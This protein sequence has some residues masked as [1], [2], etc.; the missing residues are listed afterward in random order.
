MSAEQPAKLSTSSTST[1]A[2]DQTENR[3]SSEVVRRSSRKSNRLPVLVILDG[4]NKGLRFLIENVST[5]IG[6]NS[7]AD[8]CLDDA[9]ASRHHTTLYYEKGDENHPLSCTMV[10]IG[11]RNGTF[12]NGER[13]EGE[14]E[15]NDGD[16]ILIGETVL[17]FF[18][19]DAHELQ[20][21]DYVRR[22]A[23]EDMLTGLPN[24]RALETRLILECHRSEIANRSLCVVMMDI[25]YFKSINDTFGHLAGDEVLRCVAGMIQKQLR[26]EDFAARYGG[27]EF[28]LI[29]PNTRLEEGVAVAERIRTSIGD[30]RFAISSGPPIQVTVSLGVA[31]SRVAESGLI[32]LK[33]ADLALYDAKRQGRNQV[34]HRP[35]LEPA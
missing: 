8:I 32:L 1:A 28:T 21:E 7:K 23:T 15:L 29:L 22:Q 5:S 4:S 25:D 12:V 11:S 3:H 10:D 9:V 33:A 20:V 31:Q 6:R 14:V 19:R 13:I 2:K 18:L 30:S 34:R 16:R 27:E 26:A 35:N 24:R 17:G